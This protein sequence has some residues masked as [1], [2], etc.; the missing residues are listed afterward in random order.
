VE[1]SENLGNQMFMYVYG[2]NISIN[3]QSLRDF[4][5]MK[6]KSI[7]DSIG[8]AKIAQIKHFH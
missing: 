1:I 7:H 3:I 2:S 6:H 8:V 4:I 5:V